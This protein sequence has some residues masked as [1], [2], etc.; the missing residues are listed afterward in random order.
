MQIDLNELRKFLPQNGGHLS[1]ELRDPHGRLVV[2]ASLNVQADDDSGLRVFSP[3]KPPSDSEDPPGPNYL[4][5]L[6]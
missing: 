4:S 5:I 1:V 3:D 6:T 2:S